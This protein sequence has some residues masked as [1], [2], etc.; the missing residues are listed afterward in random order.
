MDLW[1]FLAL[2]NALSALLCLSCGVGSWRSGISSIWNWFSEVLS[3]SIWNGLTDCLFFYSVFALETFPWQ[4]EFSGEMNA[5]DEE[6]YKPP[7]EFQE[8]VKEPLVELSLTDSTEL[9]L[10]QWPINHPPDFD[11]QELSV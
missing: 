3:R 2:D 5:A 6:S 1:I 11:G 8:D 4:V 10:I 7:P 9:W